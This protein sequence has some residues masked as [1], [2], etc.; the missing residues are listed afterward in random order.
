MI[1]TECRKN[2]DDVSFSLIYERIGRWMAYP[3]S[4]IKQVVYTHFDDIPEM[5]DFIHKN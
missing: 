4:K 2:D 1:E 3:F 5:V